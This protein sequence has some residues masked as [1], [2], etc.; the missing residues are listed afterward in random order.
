VAWALALAATS[1]LGQE[2]LATAAEEGEADAF[3]HSAGLFLGA[4]TKFKESGAKHYFTFAGEYEYHPESWD[5]W[6]AA[7]VVE[8]I[9]S[10]PIEALVLP[11]VY[12]HFNEQWLGRTGVGLEIGREEEEHETKAHLVWRAG[13]GYLIPLGGLLL[14]PSF[15]ADLV[16]TDIA[17]AYGFVL[18]WDF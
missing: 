13:V 5:G 10:D 16:R 11:L 2:G 14:V 12:Y 6:G 4:T 8:V 7:G 15:D 18:A 17:F 1:V 3:K 9:T